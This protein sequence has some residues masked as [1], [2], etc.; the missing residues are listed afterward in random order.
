MTA[1]VFAVV[2]RV[3]KGKSSIIA[4]LAED[5]R[6]A[7]SPD[8][9]T[10]RTCTE[11]PVRVDGELLFTLVDTPGFEEADR[12]LAWLRERE[13]DA[14]SRAR[15]VAELV[16]AHSGDDLVDER[17]LLAPV[18]AGA[19]ILYVVDGAR[20][21]RANY[22]A[23]MEVLRWTGRPRMAL[24]NR[25]G[26]GDHAEEWRAALGQYFS[27]VRDFDAHHAGFAERLSLLRAFGELDEGLRAPAARAVEAL[28]AERERR[29]AESAGLITELLVD[30][31]TLTLEAR[32]DTADALGDIRADLE[33]RF[34]DALR[35]RERAA[36]AAVAALYHHPGSWDEAELDRPTYE[37][38]LFAKRT[39][40]G[41]GLTPGQLL[42]ATTTTGAL[43]G[44]TVDAMVGAASFMTGAAIGAAAGFG[45][46]LLQLGKR[47]A[48]AKPADAL[49]DAFGK[50]RRRFRVGPHAHPNFPFVVLDRAVLHFSAVAH[51][52]HAR[53]DAPRVEGRGP[54][55]DLERPRRDALSKQF[56][57]V[58]KRWKDPPREAIDAIHAE[59][60]ML[61][62]V[63]DDYRPGQ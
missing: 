44:G 39:W 47:Y 11:F 55:A 16:E 8:P 25:I 36:R 27:V 23:E 31:C 5:P 4:T 28:V 7:I 38:D 53:Q 51:R 10:T 1:P 18:L 14:A 9:G 43:S 15:L 54:V 63:E 40:E 21:F 50:G 48:E 19:S 3:N 34:H 32:A 45:F 29:R 57:K 58:R 33:A 20:P 13:T 52:T 2:G 26:P 49:R 46:G 62:A 56:A 30:A 17:R 6:V 59:V 12:A 42:A 60:A 37:A 22:E 24:V 61:L 41:L 35:E